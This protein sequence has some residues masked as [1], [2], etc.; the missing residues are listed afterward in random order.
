[1]ESAKKKSDV[2]E[3]KTKGLEKPQAMKIEQR[4]AV[5]KL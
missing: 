1:M 5:S 2:Q 3:R 4:C